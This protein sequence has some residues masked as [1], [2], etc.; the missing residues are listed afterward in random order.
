MHIKG[1]IE[2]AKCNAIYSA[3]CELKENIVTFC[4]WFKYDFSLRQEEDLFVNHWYPDGNIVSN[5][6]F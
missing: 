4:I 5:D 6:Y 1:Y 2:K 3:I